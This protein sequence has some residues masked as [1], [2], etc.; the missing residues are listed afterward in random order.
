M[1]R[2]SAPS[3]LNDTAPIAAAAEVVGQHDSI[4]HGKRD[5][6][7]HRLEPERKFHDERRL[8]IS[9]VR[10]VF[11]RRVRGLRMNAV[12]GACKNRAQDSY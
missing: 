9:R 8:S 12:K 1:M 11:E 7:T 5:G 3:S 6:R 4:T 2:M 10:Y